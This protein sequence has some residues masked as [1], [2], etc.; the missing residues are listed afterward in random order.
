MTDPMG[1][2]VSGA[3]EQSAHIEAPLGTVWR[4]FSQ[5][6]FRDRWFTMPGERHT[7]THQ[8]D[9][10]IGGEEVTRGVFDNVGTIENLE[11]RTR[12][13]DI[14]EGQRISSFYEFRINDVLK[15]VA[16]LSVRFHEVETVTAVGGTMVS[17]TEQYQFFDVL[18]DGSAE[19]GEREGGTRFYLRRLAIA[20]ETEQSAEQ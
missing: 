3:V 6:E 13:V 15:F 1:A 4:A 12:F 16:I 8:L 20:V 18:G 5:L 19:R 7:R 11:H 14:V 17:Y 2:L 10:R 9:F